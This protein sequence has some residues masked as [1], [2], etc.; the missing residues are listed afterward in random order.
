MQKG[1]SQMV[2]PRAETPYSIVRHEAEREQRPID[3]RGFSNKGLPKSAGKNF[4]QVPPVFNQKVFNN[5]SP[6]IPDKEV[7]EA[8]GIK[9]RCKTHDK[10][11]MEQFFSHV[12]WG[13]GRSGK[14]DY[15][16]MTRVKSATR[17]SFLAAARYPTVL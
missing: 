13:T 9:K 12:S 15:T 6:V 7:S 2:S 4:R 3:L 1:I 8:I 5:E 16:T 14:E 17:I 10:E 11:D